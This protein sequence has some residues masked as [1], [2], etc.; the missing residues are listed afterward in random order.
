VAAALTFLRGWHVAYAAGTRINIKPMGSFEE[1][2][3]RIRCP[4]IWLDRADPCDSILTIREN[5]P[6][7]SLLT[8]V[9]LQ[10]EIALGT[11][12]SFSVQEVIDIATRRATEQLGVAGK[13]AIPADKD[14]YN[15]LTAVA[16]VPKGRGIS[17]DRLGRW[18]NKNNGKIVGRLKLV[19]VGNSK[20]YP[21]WQLINA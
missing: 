20:G 2:S 4:L 6:L 21:L 15:A 18:L 7:R 12:D 16:A 1:W 5:D 8:A 9:L 3:H 10:W 19:R 14:F 11:V 13:P 17:N